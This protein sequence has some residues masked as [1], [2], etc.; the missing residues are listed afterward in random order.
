MNLTKARDILQKLYHL[1]VRDV[2]LCSGARNAPFVEILSQTFW[3]NTFNFFDERAA[4]FFA[5]GKIKR[6]HRPV[7]VLTT[8]GTAV[9]ELLSAVIE[10]H[11]SSLPLIVVSSDRPQYYRHSGAPQSIKHEGIFSHYIDSFYDISHEEEQIPNLQLGSGPVHINVCFDEPLLNEDA[12]KLDTFVGEEQQ[13]V[14][15]DYLGF[16]SEADEEYIKNFFKRSQK[17]LVLISNL[18][19]KLRSTIKSLVAEWGAYVFI[20]SPS[21]IDLEFCEGVIS[22][23]DFLRSP[24][25]L[26][27]IDGVIR[28]GNVP[29]LRFWRDLEK[30]LSFLPVLSVSHLPFSGLGREK[31]IPVS[32]SSIIG[33]CQKHKLSFAVKESILTKDKELKVQVS[34][35]LER[36]SNSEPNQ[37]GLLS[38][39]ID[40]DDLIFLGNSLPIRL[41]DLSARKAHNNIYVNRGVN[42]IDGLLSTALG[43]AEKGETLWVVL[44]DLSTLY[45]LNSLWALKFLSDIQ[46]RVVVVNNQGGK[47][48]TRLFNN[49]LFENQHDLEFEHW[50]KMFSCGYTKVSHVGQLEDLLERHIIELNINLKET[51]DFWSEYDQLWKQ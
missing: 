42:G 26:R 38:Q 10:A 2:C 49:H 15:P 6:S 21:G 35:L 8:S 3:M 27:D 40:R 1:G 25:F 9:S 32:F 23:G 28:I 37:Y 7:A 11:Y 33:Y 17:P 51:D 48:F 13:Y 34:N 29:T 19:E 44:G 16:S 22:N 12:F 45:D 24:Q 31:N 50:A 43:L 14:K 4:S 36:Y 30:T 18:P 20:E 39:M 46:L 47:I 41:W 5:L